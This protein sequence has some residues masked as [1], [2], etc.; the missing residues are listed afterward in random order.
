METSAITN[1]TLA[2]DRTGD[3]AAHRL[4]HERRYERLLAPSTCHL[5]T[6]VDGPR[7]GSRAWRVT[8]SRPSR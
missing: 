3:E 1:E 8:A 5:P 4:V 6:A 2:R 7:L